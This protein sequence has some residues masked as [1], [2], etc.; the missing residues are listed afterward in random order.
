MQKHI[1]WL[2][3][4]LVTESEVSVEENSNIRLMAQ[5]DM[6][7]LIKI[8]GLNQIKRAVVGFGSEWL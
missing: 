3:E 7:G 8:A 6:H 1:T 4:C 2:I 5:V